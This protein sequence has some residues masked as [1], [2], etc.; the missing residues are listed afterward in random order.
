MADY[1]SYIRKMVGHSK[2]FLDGAC[3]AVT[4]EMGRILLQK[5]NG[6][7]K[8]GL[9]GGLSEL[10]ESL[11]QTALRELREETGLIGEVDCLVGIYS[12][13]DAEYTNGDKAQCIVTLFG[14]HTVGGKLTCDGVET[15]ELGYFPSD[16]LPEIFCKQHEDMIN[17]FF[18]G[19]RG[20][21]K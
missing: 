9:P 20:V 7:G 11:E 4:D 15:L 16:G 10:G 13:Y 17:D 3:I 18:S 5:R 6:S 14:G 12:A 8:W 21:Y 2:I 19:A 1:I